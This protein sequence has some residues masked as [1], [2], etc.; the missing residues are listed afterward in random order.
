VRLR[1]VVRQ[2]WVHSQ[3]RDRIPLDKPGEAKRIIRNRKKSG[4]DREK[5]GLMITTSD[6]SRR[7]FLPPRRWR[8][9]CCRSP[10]SGFWCASAEERKFGLAKARRQKTW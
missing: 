10:P 5:R 2:G 3:R 9:A 6:E 8:G 4:R 7:G 1:G